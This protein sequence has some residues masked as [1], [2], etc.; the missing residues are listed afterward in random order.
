MIEASHRNL[1]L[2]AIAAMTICL[3]GPAVAQGG[4]TC[5]GTTPAAALAAFYAP[6][7]LASWLPAYPGA[8]YVLV[9]VYAAPPPMQLRPAASGVLKS[10]AETDRPQPVACWVA[11]LDPPG[12]PQVRVTAST[13]SD[14][15]A[16]G[17][18]MIA[19]NPAAGG[20]APF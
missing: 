20:A 3:A 10:A 15:A 17:G 9:P 11:P 16:I 4:S 7:A 8:T 12:H 6:S 2:S 18:L 13:R 19:Q 14:C 1:R 5:L